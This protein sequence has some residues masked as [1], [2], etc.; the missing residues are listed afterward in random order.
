M[1]VCIVRRV[2]ELKTARCRHDICYNARLL[3][4]IMIAVCSYGQR[5]EL[6]KR[7]REVMVQKKPISGMEAVIIHCESPSRLETY[8]YLVIMM[9]CARVVRVVR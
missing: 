4:M 7:A 8:F 5:K 3:M 2:M 1:M 6:D 9:A